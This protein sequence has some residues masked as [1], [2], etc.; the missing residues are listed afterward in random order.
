MSPINGRWGE[1]ADLT[2]LGMPV[3]INVVCRFAVMKSIGKVH[4][5]TPH[6]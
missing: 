5:D 4:S 1:K 6:S 2:N 3:P